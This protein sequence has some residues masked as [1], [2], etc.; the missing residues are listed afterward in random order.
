MEL[1]YGNVNLPIA[2]CA[3]F[4]F[5]YPGLWAFV[6]LTKPTCA[7]GLLWFLLRRDWRAL[8]WAVGLTALVAVP[9][10]AFR[11]DL[12]SGYVGML[13]NNA[14]VAQ[15]VPLLWRL[16]VAAVL[17]AWGARS[18]R[19]WV[20]P[21]AAALAVPKLAWPTLAIL[22]GVVPLL[23]ADAGTTFAAPLPSGAQ[24]GASVKRALLRLRW[25]APAEARS[26][27]ADGDPRR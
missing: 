23:S 24:V 18:D 4:G 25:R 26:A 7:I 8:A 1:H 19:R 20:V 15:A 17:V 21:V 11:P 5:A 22:A 27:T 12:W 10:V 2:V 14:G 3:A 13:T 9:T 16:P 6:L